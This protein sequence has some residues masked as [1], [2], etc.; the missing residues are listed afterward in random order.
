MTAGM[1]VLALAMPQLT[2]AQ[3]GTATTP[4]PDAAVNPAWQYGAF[5]DVGYLHDFNEPDNKVFR[6]RGTAWHV[7]DVRLNMAGVYAKKKP[8][9]KSRWGS[10]VLIHAGKDDEIFGFSAT[11]PNLRGSD[12][13]RHVG[14]A[15][16]SYLVPARAGLIL[17]S[18][19]F[20]SLIGYDS[21]YA[22]DNLNYTR[23]W[24]ADFTPT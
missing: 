14:L 17:Q 16:V 24:G 21:L 12:V 4:A 18:G 22:K 1:V 6:S 5:V 19:V 11:A 8:S 23:P 2:F 9:A 20:A 7:D 10:E 3:S 15:N 13:L